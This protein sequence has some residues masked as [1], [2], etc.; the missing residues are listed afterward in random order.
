MSLLCFLFDVKPPFQTQG[1]AAVRQMWEDCTSRIPLRLKHETSSYCQRKLGGGTLAIR[2]MGWKSSG[3]ADVDARH[4]CLPENQ[5]EW[6]IRHEHLSV[7][8]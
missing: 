1:K 3:N 6:Q 5:G 2:F 7:P 4:R 8:F